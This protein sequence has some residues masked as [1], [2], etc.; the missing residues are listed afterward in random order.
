MGAALLVRRR[1]TLRVLGVISLLAGI[2]AGA[3]VFLLVRD[4]RT[5]SSS[6]DLAAREGFR[7]TGWKAI[8]LGGLVCLVLLWL[9]FASWIAAGRLWIEPDP[10]RRGGLVVGQ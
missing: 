1:A 8:G 5:L 6:M 3:G 4:F 7:I 2:A 10:G 9:G